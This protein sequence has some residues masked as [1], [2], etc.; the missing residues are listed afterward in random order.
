MKTIIE[1]D[2]KDNIINKCLKAGIVLM[3]PSL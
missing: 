1:I 2:N 3:S